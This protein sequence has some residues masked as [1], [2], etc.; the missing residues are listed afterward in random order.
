M[1]FEGRLTM[2][3][4]VAAAFGSRDGSAD[5]T[6]RPSGSATRAGD[7]QMP[8]RIDGVLR[9]LEPDDDA[10]DLAEAPEAMAGRHDAA[11]DLVL[12]ARRLDIGGDVDRDIRPAHEEQHRGEARH[13][14]CP[15][16]Q[17]LA[18]RECDEADH[19]GAAR[20]QLF[21]QASHQQRADK[22]ADRNAE[23]RQRQL[24]RA[25]AELRLKVGNAWIE[26]VHFRRLD[27]E[28]Q[29]HQPGR[30]EQLA[31]ASVFPV[32]FVRLRRAMML[33]AS[34]PVENAIAA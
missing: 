31:H 5:A 12:H 29:H 16:R 2:G 24:G 25:D 18:D 32:F 27:E 1:A 6:H 11:A 15:A 20:R 34:T 21:D 28:R 14:P 9:E 10:E 19:D 17:E 3:A 8:A 4:R 30:R 23:Q 7:Q 33:R 13:I 22:P 26:V